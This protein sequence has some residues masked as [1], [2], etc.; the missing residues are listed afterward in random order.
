[1][2][3]LKLIKANIKSKKESF[4][5]IAI[6][7]AIITCMLATIISVT[8]C[9]DSQ[10]DNAISKTNTGDI[11]YIYNSDEVDND[12]IKEITSMNEVEKVIQ[13]PCISSRR[14]STKLREYRSMV[15]FFAYEPDKQMY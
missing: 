3:I 14:V 2:A 1:M 12:M 4:I 9:L 7:V 13:I 8:V 6:L 15:F 5:G 11:V 10:Y